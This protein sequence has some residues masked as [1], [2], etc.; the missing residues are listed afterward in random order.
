M[1]PMNPYK[2]SY[3]DLNADLNDLE[4]ALCITLNY[5]KLKVATRTG[6]KHTT[7]AENRART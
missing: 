5:K 1:L 7:K 4:E 2:C 3:W 6:Q